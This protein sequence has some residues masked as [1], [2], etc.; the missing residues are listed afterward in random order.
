LNTRVFRIIG[1]AIVGAIIGSFLTGGSQVGIWAGLILGGAG[2][3]LPLMAGTSALR[4]AYCRKRVKL[5]AT[6]CH[7][8]GRAVGRNAPQ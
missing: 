6:H 7:H 1:V 5:G 4:C 3:V 2:G 8:C